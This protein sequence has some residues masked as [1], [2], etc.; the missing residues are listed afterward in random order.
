LYLVE[1]DG[2]RSG[3]P[4]KE[5]VPGENED[6]AGAPFT[7]ENIHKIFQAENG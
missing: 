7:K 6:P 3:S 5:M 1:K 2:K 4:S